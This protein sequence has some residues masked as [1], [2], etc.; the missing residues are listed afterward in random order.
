MQRSVEA[1]VAGSLP[2][3][4]ENCSRTAAL[5]VGDG[6]GSELHDDAGELRLGCRTPNLEYSVYLVYTEIC[7]C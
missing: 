5:Q 1:A 7:H 4:L 6:D 2:A 3:V